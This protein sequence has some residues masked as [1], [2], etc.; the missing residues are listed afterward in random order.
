MTL[1]LTNTGTLTGSEVVQL[2]ITL[3]PTG[4][5]TPALQLRG[6]G[7]AKDLGPGES[8]VVKISLDKYAVSYWDAVRNLWTAKAGQY[9]VSIGKSSADIVSR[10][11]FTLERGFTWSG[12]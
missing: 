6:F 4:L 5:T 11:S 1:T 7:K 2:Y 8:V 3:P 12:L 9:V 10:S